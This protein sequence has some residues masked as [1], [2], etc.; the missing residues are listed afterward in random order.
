MKKNALALPFAVGA[1]LLLAG[2][3]GGTLTDRR[4]G[5]TYKTV[6]IGTQTWM[7]ENLN[8]ESDDSWC[9]DG[10]SSD[11]E[12]Y[13]RLYT[14]DAAMEACPSGWHLPTDAEFEELKEFAG[15]DFLNAGFSAYFWSA[16]EG[17]VS[18][19]RSMSL[20]LFDVDAYLDD[21]SKRNAFSVR[22]LKD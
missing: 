19:A 4:D 16:T 12:K 8:Y 18:G 21:N 20:G 11:C 15:G 6:K 10:K 13:G 3:G 2:C 7:A 22:C 5:Q 14:W 9:Y 1:F 17:Y